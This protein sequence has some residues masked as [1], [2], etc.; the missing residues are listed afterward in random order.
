[1][2]TRADRQSSLM[3]KVRRIKLLQ[4]LDELT[5]KLCNKCYPV[6]KVL[7]SGGCDCQASLRI[8]GIGEELL[9][10]VKTPTSALLGQ[11]DGMKFED[12]TVELYLVLDEMGINDKIICSR[13]QIGTMRFME[14]KRENELVRQ[15]VTA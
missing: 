14:W 11:L 13:L 12:F 5:P 10:L 8:A 6:T 4:E 3:M 7:K 2:R 1:M 15:V 9:E